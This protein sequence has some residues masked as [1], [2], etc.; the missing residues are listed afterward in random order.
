MNFL[1]TNHPSSRLTGT[2][3]RSITVMNGELLPASC[4]VYCFF[5]SVPTSMYLK[6]AILTAMQVAGRTTVC[7]TAGLQGS[8][9]GSEGCRPFVGI[10]WNRRKWIEIREEEREEKES[11]MTED[12]MFK[13]I[14]AFWQTMKSDAWITRTYRLT[15]SQEQCHSHTYTVR[16][17]DFW[18]PQFNWQMHVGWRFT[19]KHM[20]CRPLCPTM[21]ERNACH[22]LATVLLLEFRQSL[23]GK[24]KYSN[25][26][27][28]RWCL[29]VA[30]DVVSSVL[31]AASIAWME[32]CFVVS[33]SQRNHA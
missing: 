28:W 17:P 4:P 14:L 20:W 2:S 5:G 8:L 25:N 33:M 11:K 16:Y 29:M 19:H 15:F 9:T 12:E 23:F 31:A 7:L 3:L 22:K 30:L 26:K 10:F 24:A 27:A 21:H 6:M 18:V 13:V 1:P 32:W